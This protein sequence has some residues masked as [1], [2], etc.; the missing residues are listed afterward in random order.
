MATQ[1]A[2]QSLD[3]ARENL[4]IK[5]IWMIA[6]CTAII[7]AIPVTIFKNTAP[8]LIAVPICIGTIVALG[9][10]IW[11]LM[12]RRGFVS[13]YG[14]ISGPASGIPSGLEGLQEYQNFSLQLQYPGDTEGQSL[15]SF[16]NSRAQPPR[17]PRKIQLASGDEISVVSVDR[18]VELL[19]DRLLRDSDAIVEHAMTMG[20]TRFGGSG[21]LSKVIL[22][23]IQADFRGNWLTV[24]SRDAELVIR[25]LEEKLKT[26]GFELKG[27]PAKPRRRHQ[28]KGA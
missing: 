7:G 19:V 9:F 25:D 24:V 2:P 13:S 14:R 15:F 27:E 20:A 28:S 10:E 22:E 1:V 16:L 18:Y 11:D 26:E 4:C 21:K 3:D 8:W 5:R 23:T 6:I 12:K 17:K